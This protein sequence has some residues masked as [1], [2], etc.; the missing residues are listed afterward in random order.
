MTRSVLKQS[1][2]MGSL[3]GVQL[4]GAE[5]LLT[6]IGWQVQRDKFPLRERYRVIDEI[7]E[8]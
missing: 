8:R 4:G 2:K 3:E 6:P 1:Q 5:I 7:L